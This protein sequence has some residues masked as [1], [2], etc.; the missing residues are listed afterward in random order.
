[1]RELLRHEIKSNLQRLISERRRHAAIL[2][3]QVCWML[4]LLPPVPVPVSASVYISGEM[5]RRYSTD[6]HACVHVRNKENSS[7]SLKD[8]GSAIVQ[9]CHVHVQVHIER[10]LVQCPRKRKQKTANS[11]RSN[12]DRHI[13][14]I[15]RPCT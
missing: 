1:M 4:P 2:H 5:Q 14:F 6:A 9:P 8:S 7:L 10:A 15:F 12:D 3:I 11:K 13:F